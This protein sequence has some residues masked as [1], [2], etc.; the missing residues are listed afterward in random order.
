MK[1]NKQYRIRY[2][3][4]DLQLNASIVSILRIFEDIALLQSESL[5]VGLNYYADNQV[6]WML[7]KW[8]I[9]IRSFPKLNEIVDV[10]TK[11][12]AFKDF[13]A[14]RT[15][16]I[17]NTQSEELI[18]ANTLWLFIDLKTMRPKRVSDEMFNKYGL[19]GES[20]E[21]FSKLGSIKLPD[22]FNE[23]K[24]FNVR[25]RDIDTNLHA[26]NS[27]YVEWAMETL[28]DDFIL[29]NKMIKLKVEYRK[30]LKL[31][32][33]LNSYSSISKIKNKSEIFHLIRSNDFDCCKLH[34][35]WIA[36]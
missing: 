7:N 16:H 25:R 4:C 33:Q 13:Y 10:E 18:S 26:N 23:F 8:E 22:N 14:N 27:A 34:S 2:Y 12:T 31:H 3:N 36:R 1:F 32:E 5:G 35:I 24:S 9:N 20:E 28:P 15:Y 6:A 30:Q 19:T 21:I 11:P 17:Y 29:N